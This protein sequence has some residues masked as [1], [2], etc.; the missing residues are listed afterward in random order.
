MVLF[1]LP[2]LGVDH[3]P[4]ERLAAVWEDQVALLFL[5]LRPGLVEH[6]SL[7]LC[8]GRDQD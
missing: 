8:P 7:V 3:V 2:L 1:R 4:W 6:L 5:V